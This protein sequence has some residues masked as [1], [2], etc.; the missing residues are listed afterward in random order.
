MLVVDD[1]EEARVVLTQAL[2]EYGAQVTA[3]SSGAEALAFLSRPAG[4]QAARRR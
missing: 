4:R 1:Q 3:V 2:S